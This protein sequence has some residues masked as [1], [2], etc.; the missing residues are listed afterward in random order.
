M[1]N[2]EVQVLSEP[3]S[4]RKKQVSIDAKQESAVFQLIE[5]CVDVLKYGINWI[6]S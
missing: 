6:R 4:S 2:A 5:A 3:E 1:E